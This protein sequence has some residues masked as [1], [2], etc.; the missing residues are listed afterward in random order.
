MPDLMA[1][2]ITVEQIKRKIE[3]YAEN[4]MNGTNI[5]WISLV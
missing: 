5:S 2:E 3:I 4:S 1:P